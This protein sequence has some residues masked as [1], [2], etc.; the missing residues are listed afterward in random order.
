MNV[1]LLTF[2]RS[3]SVMFLIMS[4]CN[5]RATSESTAPPGSEPKSPELAQS[6]QPSDLVNSGHFDVNPVALK[7]WL[8]FIESGKYRAANANDFNFSESAKSR[9]RSM[10][11]DG[12]YFQ[13][14]HPAITGNINRR[15]DFKDLAVIV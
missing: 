14:N 7:A 5:F 13:V 15:L 12:W 9:L 6:G 1:S 11:E 3:A 8:T 2:A 10:F 4:G